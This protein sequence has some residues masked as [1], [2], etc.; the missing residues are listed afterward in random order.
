M[1]NFLSDA[2]DTRA[3]DLAL[4]LVEQLPV[5]AYALDMDGHVLIWNR[6]CEILTGVPA[7]EVLGTNTQ[8]QAFFE[9]P[10]PCPADL[11]H[12]GRAAEIESLYGAGGI[13]IAGGDAVGAAI[14][15]IP[16][17]LGSERYL[18]FETSAIR[19]DDGDIVAVV[20]IVRDLTREKRSE[21]VLERLAASDALTGLANRPTFDR[22][23]QIEWQ[24]AVREGRPLAV[25]MIDLDCFALFNETYGPEKGDHCLK[26]VAEAIGGELG[27]GNGF[28]ARFG[29]EKFAVILPDTAM[30]VAA[31]VADAM[32]CAVAERRL[33]HRTSSAAPFVSLSIGVASGTP[34]D[35]RPEQLLADAD[36]GLGRAKREGRNRCSA[37]RA[38][39]TISAVDAFDD[40]PTT[41]EALRR[42]RDLKVGA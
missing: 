15:C 19:D 20:E 35:T 21:M 26:V 16:P 23:L 18:A 22:M 39:M 27:A 29:G 11:V 38:G 28:A 33:P 34:L 12:H 24:R 41:R 9:T 32:R 37:S 31:E 30:G 1:L 8:G 7:A 14:W 17:R 40:R 6:A 36:A 42:R 3:Q 2:A 5:A 4:L 25:L 13:P 10:R